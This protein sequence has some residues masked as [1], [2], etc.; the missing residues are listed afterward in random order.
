MCLQVRSIYYNLID[1]C[2]V[3][4]AGKMLIKKTMLLGRIGDENV[5][6][7][8]KCRCDGTSAY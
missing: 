2:V 4:L 7:L 1:L 8:P 6:G 3:L 5:Q